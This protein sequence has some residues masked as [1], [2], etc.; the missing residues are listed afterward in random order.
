VKVAVDYYINCKMKTSLMRKKL[1]RVFDTLFYLSKY[2]RLNL[3]I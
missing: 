2:A 1:K 3:Y